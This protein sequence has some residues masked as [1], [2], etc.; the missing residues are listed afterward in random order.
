MREMTTEITREL[1]DEQKSNVR[2][3]VVALRSGEYEQA[4]RCLRDN[5]GRMCCLGVACD[6][7]RKETG[8]GAWDPTDDP[9][10]VFA[11]RHERVGSILPDVVK[12][13]LGVLERNPL[14]DAQTSAAGMNDAGRPF[15]EI[16][17]AIEEAYL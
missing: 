12:N 9:G 14:L 10:W 5:G 8:D 7:Y 15:E 17:D 3:W 6:L 11:T 4:T 1:T 2:R 13:W 16:A